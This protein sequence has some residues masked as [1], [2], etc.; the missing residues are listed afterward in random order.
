MIVV[1]N[2]G[3]Q[4]AHLIARRIRELGV[5]SELVQP[6]ISISN[7]KKLNP[8]AI[9]LS[10][11]P[12]SVYEKDSP[13]VDSEIYDLQIPILGICYGMQLMAYQLKG[14]VTNHQTKQFG[15]ISLAINKSELFGTLKSPQTVWFSHGDAVDKLPIGFN[16]IAKTTSAPI[17][18]FENIK[19]K[20]YGIQFHPEVT[21]TEGG[22]VVLS[23]FLF[24]IA[25]VKKDW[26]LKEVKNQIVNNLK[27]QLA[28][29]KVL[30]ALSGGVDS[31]VAATL[32]R[33]AVGENLYPV[34]IDTGLF[35]SYGLAAF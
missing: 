7:L 32:I 28:G 13:K 9:I 6:D 21:H 2:F 22:S 16:I 35:R 31:L 4:Y 14:K 27:K 25:K 3:G 30:M 8:K 15:K 1:I 18:G 34:F 23:N 26:D 5:K 33:E 17:A 11:S 19:C 24:K 29:K 20:F 12:F 10:G